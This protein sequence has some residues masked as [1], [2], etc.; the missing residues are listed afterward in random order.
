[1]QFL[2]LLQKGIILGQT[3]QGQLV[4]NL[5]VLRPGHVALLKISDLDGVSGAEQTNLAFLVKHLKN[6]LDALLELS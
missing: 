2:A 3:L 5:N 1:M 4:R 6:L